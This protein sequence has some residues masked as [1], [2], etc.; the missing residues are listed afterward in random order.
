M[1]EKERGLKGILQNRFLLTLVLVV[2]WSGFMEEAGISLEIICFLYKNTKMKRNHSNTTSNDD[3]DKRHKTTGDG[4][5]SYTLVFADGSTIIFDPTTSAKSSLLCNLDPDSPV[6]ISQ[7]HVATARALLTLLAS[8]DNDMSYASHLT[9]ELYVKILRLCDYLGMDENISTALLLHLEPAVQEDPLARLRACHFQLPIFARILYQ[10]Y[11][12]LFAKEGD[13]SSF[14]SKILSSSPQDMSYDELSLCDVK[15]SPN[16]T[17]VPLHRYA[18]CERERR[19]SVHTAAV[20]KTAAL[21]AALNDDT[22][23]GDGS[24]TEDVLCALVWGENITNPNTN[25][26]NITWSKNFLD[27]EMWKA[28]EQGNIDVAKRLLELGAEPALTK[29][30]KLT[31]N[32]QSLWE[33]R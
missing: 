7:F 9:P 2:K 27:Q 17:N 1:Q 14:V 22:L 32:Y 18:Q 31:S 21:R 26:T 5:G 16:K 29:D 13:M 4:I 8:N 3:D 20:A 30:P 33:H 10:R 12:T 11:D 23:V 15:Y 25:T 6:P 24:A 28:I 19:L